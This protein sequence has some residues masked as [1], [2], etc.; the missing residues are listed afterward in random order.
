MEELISYAKNHDDYLSRLCVVFHDSL[1]YSGSIVP[2]HHPVPKLLK[3]PTCMRDVRVNI[4][5]TQSRIV[6]RADGG[7]VPGAHDVLSDLVDAVI[8]VACGVCSS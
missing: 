3:V 7:H 5:S 6:S 8:H 1:H 4:I 2:I